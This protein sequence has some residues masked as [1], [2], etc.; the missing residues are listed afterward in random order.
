ML[1]GPPCLNCLWLQ[2]SSLTPW[3]L[4]CVTPR[5]LYSAQIPPERVLTAQIRTAGKGHVGCCQR[6]CSTRVR[7]LSDARDVTPLDGRV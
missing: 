7:T 5:D 2:T 1:V 3:I 6:V 4:Q